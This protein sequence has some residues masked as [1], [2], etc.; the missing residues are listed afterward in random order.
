VQGAIQVYLWVFVGMNLLV[1]G[2]W[3][4]HGHAAAS[5]PLGDVQQRFGDL[6]RFSGKYQIGDLPNMLDMEGLAG[7]LFPR[8]YPPFA[9]IVYVLLLQV[10]A[11]YALVAMLTAV[12]G[13]M[14]AACMSLWREVRKFAGYRWYM[15]AA[16]FLTGL[17][18][19]GTEHAVMRGNIEGL[20]WIAVC[21][22]AALY[23]RKDYSGAA[24]SFGVA[25]CLKPQPVLWLALMARH[26]KYRAA[27]LGL[28]V[29]AAVT[30][31]SL[32]LINPNPVRAYH[33]VFSA[34]GNFFPH[35]IVS[36]RPMQEMKQD[37]SLLQ[38]VKTMARVVRY[39]S[40]NLP[41]AEY[42]LTR[43]NDPLA[44]KLYHV[45]L[46][47]SVVLGL[48][49]LWRVWNKPV[50]NQMFALACA[51][52]VLPTMAADY[53]LMVLLVPMGFFLIFLLQDVA[54]GRV[55]MSL[56]AMLCFL[57]PCAWIMATEPLSVLH[58]VLKC[59]AVL[60]LLGASL[61]IPLPS[62][63]FGEIART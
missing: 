63:R 41:P 5:F 44:W 48:V 42:R 25:C 61:A 56:P 50:L 1:W 58:G 13:G 51:T 11:P 46:P 53:T 10:C 24:I 19:W 9:A 12:L 33:I 34:S 57:L 2:G 17:F 21:A 47:L 43:P 36:F 14:L 6:V 35:Y 27:A 30:M 54:E 55:R 37:H 18:G 16:I 39:R 15:G 59:V 40:L 3:V 26:R 52:T 38:S 49:A 20:V 62:S 28:G 7:T 29:A 60:A 32:L 8:N 31:M 22:G 45:C 23:A 4:L